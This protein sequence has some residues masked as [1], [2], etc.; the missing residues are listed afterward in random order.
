MSRWFRGC[1]CRPAL[2]LLV[3]AAVAVALPPAG[4]QAQPAARGLGRACPEGVPAAG[5]ADIADNTHEEAIDC[6]ALYGITTGTDPGVF[7]PAG[8]VRRGQ[9]ASFMVR[10][11]AIAGLS[12]PPE[13]PAPFTDV[14]SDNVHSPAIAQLAELGVV[15]GYPDGTF[16]PGAPVRR[17]QMTAFL[18]RSFAE[19]ASQPLVSGQRFFTDTAG[20][21][22]EDDI[23]ALAGHGVAVGAGDG[24][25]QPARPVRRD[26]MASFVMRLAD[27][28]AEEGLLFTSVFAVTLDGYLVVDDT[29]PAAVRLGAGDPDSLGYA[30]LG[31]HSGTGRLCYRVAVVADGPFTEAHLHRAAM[32]ATGPTA[33][34][35]QPPD[36]DTG[37]VRECLLVDTDVLTEIEAD[38]TAFAVDVHTRRFPGG[39]ARGQVGT[40]HRA[41]ALAGAF[42]ADDS[43]GTVAF[44]RGQTDAT[45]IAVLQVD[46]TTGA[47]CA[48]VTTD[49][50]G[51]YIGAR[52]HRGAMNATGPGVLDLPVPGD[53]TG[54]AGGCVDADPALLAEIVADSPAFYVTVRTQGHPAGAV[55]S[56]LAGG[57][58]GIP[59]TGAH[60]VD[61]DGQPG[62]GE[63]GASGRAWLQADFV[64]GFTCYWLTTDATGPFLDSQ[65][66]RA[67]AGQ[68]GPAVVTLVSP[69]DTGQVSQCQQIDPHILAETAHVERFSFVIKTQAYPEGAVRGHFTDG[70]LF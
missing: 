62:R 21:V 3:V 52:I 41:V 35:L 18:N 29:D 60:V 22:H 50:S 47:L 33:V 67:P 44:G 57:S 36:D 28:L 69:D 46:V 59:L 61:A 8:T 25:F 24:T 38:P 32:D 10:L 65:I 45:G 48:S 40:S 54:E 56:Q 63:P 1:R 6:L 58:L 11:L 43:G 5:L 13:E 17:D 39:V 27:V 26:Q 66:I 16:R 23:N 51:P 42:V 53:E 9:M 68:N 7:S 64:S 34:S 31:L 19:V 15:G 55:R 12:L 14:A 70:L 49:A 4:A 20:N 30:F 2:A 37:R